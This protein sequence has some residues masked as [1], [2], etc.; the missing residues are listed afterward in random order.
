MVGEQDTRAGNSAELRTP[1]SSDESAIVE[2]G[3]NSYGVR[4]LGYR[5]ARDAR[6]LEALPDSA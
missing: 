1:L 3:A 5:G 6:G 2:F 4:G